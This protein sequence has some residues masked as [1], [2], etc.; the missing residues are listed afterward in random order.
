[1]Y[2]YT[3]IAGYFHNDWKFIFYGRGYHAPSWNPWMKFTVWQTLG[4]YETKPLVAE[5]S[6]CAIYVPDDAHSGQT[7]ELRQLESQLHEWV[8]PISTAS[9]YRNYLL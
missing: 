6:T 3:G 8:A 2:F 1:M 4:N 5:L 9:L 7:T